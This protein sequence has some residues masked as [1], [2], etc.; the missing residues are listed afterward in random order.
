MLMLMRDELQS[1]RMRVIESVVVKDAAE[2]E[3]ADI[4]IHNEV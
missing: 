4:E 1:R 2:T 3:D